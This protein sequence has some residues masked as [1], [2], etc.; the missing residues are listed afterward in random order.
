MMAMASDEL[1]L[2]CDDLIILTD[3][4]NRWWR[5]GIPGFAFTAF[6]DCDLVWYGDY[7]LFFC[8]GDE[9]IR[10]MSF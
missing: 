4:C 10:D 9:L 3:G 1:A 8:D 2:L 7:G 6:W 5:G